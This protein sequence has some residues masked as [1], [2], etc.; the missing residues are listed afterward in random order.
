LSAMPTL[1]GT[2]HRQGGSRMPAS[3]SHALDRLL[4]YHHG[5]ECPSCLTPINGENLPPR[6]TG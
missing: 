6:A 1:Q 2:S 4:E 3:S 5:R